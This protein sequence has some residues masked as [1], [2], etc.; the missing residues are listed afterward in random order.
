MQTTPH[1]NQT[2][3]H[4]VATNAASYLQSLHAKFWTLLTIMVVDFGT[5]SQLL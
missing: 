1:E 2:F 4:P 3:R 5:Y